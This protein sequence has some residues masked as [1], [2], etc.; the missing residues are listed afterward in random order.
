MLINWLKYKLLHPIAISITG[1]VISTVHDKETII[2]TIDGTVTVASY[3]T[4]SNN[5]T[6]F[7]TEFLTLT[8]SGI[9]NYNE[10]KNV[11]T[12]QT[13]AGTNAGTFTI[14]DSITIKGPKNGT[15]IIAG[16]II[17]TFFITG[18][19]VGIF[20]VTGTIICMNFPKIL[21]TILGTILGTVTIN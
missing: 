7:T 13:N 18:F 4:K 5:Y 17:G 19:K 21:R 1:T 15:I 14:N 8:R 6:N 2:E 11:I 3:L 12:H 20:T 9:I 10:I 16:P